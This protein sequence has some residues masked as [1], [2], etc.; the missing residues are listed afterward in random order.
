MKSENMTSRQ[1]A[2]TDPLFKK[3]CELAKIEPTK[4]QASKFRSDRG[5]GIA[6]RF[7]SEASLLLQGETQGE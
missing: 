6:R 7:V 2:A 4:R 1:F 3:C 5:K